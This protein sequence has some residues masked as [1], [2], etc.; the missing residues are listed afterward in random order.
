M[1]TTGQELAGRFLLVRQLSNGA[2]PVWLAR[3]APPMQA[4]R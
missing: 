1:F 3:G 2:R 4:W